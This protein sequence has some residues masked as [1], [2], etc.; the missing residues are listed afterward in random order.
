MSS[1]SFI[2]QMK[3]VFRP[4]LGLLIGAGIGLLIGT[5]IGMIAGGLSFGD[6]CKGLAAIDLGEMLL[7]CVASFVFA[8]IAVV[9]QIILHEA[10]HLVMGL[11]TGYGFVS[12]RIFNLTLLRQDGK[13]RIK[14]FALAGTG[15]QCLMSP[16]DKPLAD[17]DTRWYNLGGVMMN[18]LTAIICIVCAVVFDVNA[19]V[20]MFLFMMAF[21]GICFALLNGIPMKMA[22]IGN[23]GYNILNL[24]REP[25][26][27]RY[28]CNMLAVNAC[29]QKGEHIE[30]MP[31]EWFG[32]DGAIDWSNGLEA[33]WRIMCI[34]RLIAEHRWQ[35]AY[36][37]MREAL[38]SGKE[39]MKTLLLELK[40]EMVF[41]CLVLGKTD[42]AR[43]YFDD[44]VRKYAARY[45]STQSSKKRL[46]AAWSL[47]AEN[48]SATAEDIL[49]YMQTHR[50]DY[51]IR[52]EVDMD[53]SL[54]E[55]LLLH[56]EM[57]AVEN[58]ECENA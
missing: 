17:I 47:G 22:G 5:V 51:L 49:S 53:I 19:W 57:N 25:D 23:D 44:D 8:S 56:N 11:L 13:F 24:E 50:D 36:N 30:D 34:T 29:L 33:N 38:S 6:I 7:V 42:E 20:S 16:P 40:C 28:L 39:I 27:K 9:L 58:G 10:G 52:G 43:T 37:A 2:I 18:V 31:A 41:T 14:R 3:K 15:G 26:N 54:T 46:M 45:S 48:D 21:I 4:L 1:A 55:Y 35:E 32:F 12:F